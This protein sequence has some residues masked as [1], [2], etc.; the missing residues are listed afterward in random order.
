MTALKL[1]DADKEIHKCIMDSQNFY[2][3]AGAGSGKTTSLVTA[4]EF[5]RDLK[6]NHLRRDSQKVVCITYTKRAVKVIKSR[7]GFDELFL[8]TTLHNFLWNEIKRFGADIQHT[9]INSVLPKH[10]E[11]QREFDNGGKSKKAMEARAKIEELEKKLEALKEIFKYE[12]NDSNFSDYEQGLLGHD[13]V[14]ATASSM[15]MNYGRLQRLIGQK[16]PYIFVDEAQDTFESVVNALNQVCKHKDLPLI[17]YFGDPMQQIYE[18]RAGNF[19]GPAGSH[20]ITKK[21]NYRCSVSVINLLNAFRE[22]LT[23][24]PAGANQAVSGSVIIRLIQSEKPTESRNRYSPDQLDRALEKFD[25]TLH[26]W[27]WSD[28][29]IKQLY[30]TRQMI[31]R[32]L[33]FSELQSLFSGNYASQ[34][35]QDDYE[36]GDHF[37]LKP[38]SN[39]IF[40]LIKAHRSENFRQLIEILKNNSPA[41]DPK[42]FNSTNKIGS[43]ISLAKN[44][45]KKLEELWEVGTIREILRYCHENKLY[46]LS[47]K[48]LEHLNRKPR[49][50]EYSDKLHAEE[51]GD[52]LADCFLSMSTTEIGYYCEFINENTPFST[53]HGVKGE[54]Y[55]SVL[56]VFDDI[57]AAWNNYSF[58][59][60]L[61]PETSGAPKDSMKDRT[62]KLAYVCFSRAVNDL[63]IVLFTSDVE[64]AKKELID[65]KLFTDDQIETA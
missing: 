20:Q 29:E 26:D 25:K 47:E 33:G 27:K 37:L 17:G 40:N 56:V 54:E 11:K 18:K 44:M 38:F 62:K 4:L 22:D 55:E 5:I 32:R 43:M 28:T 30:L 42:G 36:S 50:E 7:V 14:I 58:A 65:Q 24:I 64:S 19:L 12:Y 63:R 13:D 46:S 2:M 59:K 41:F 60:L 15:L 8:V 16:Y 52:W 10:I 35:A 1:T 53:Q 34:K 48:A 6:G 9:L 57:E 21:E 39:C 45:A 31:A 23:Q 49:S 3:I 51:K 61:T